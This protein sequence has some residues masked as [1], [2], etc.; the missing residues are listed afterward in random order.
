MT[1]PQ[2]SSESHIR[3]LIAQHGKI[4]FAQ[5][6][7]IALYEPGVGYYSEPARVSESGDFFTSPATHPAF[8]ALL[9]VQL[10]QMWLALGSPD[11]FRVMEMG[12]G[13]GLLGDDIVSFTSSL[14]AAFASA[15][16]Y[17]RLDRASPEFST[18]ISAPG[19]DCSEPFHCV[20][21]NELLDAFPVLL[22]QIE[23][24][25]VREKFVTQNGDHLEF[26]LD[27]VS[28]PEIAS[29]IEPYLG[30][31]P[32]GYE[33]EICLG[34]MSWAEQLSTNVTSGYVISIDYGYTRDA[35]YAPQRSLGTLQC[36]YRHTV[37]AD[38]MARIGKQDISA[39]VDFTA[40]D[41]AMAAKG[42]EA[43]ANVSQAELLT[44]LG[45]EA[46][47]D[48]LIAGGLPQQD[49]KSNQYALRALT[50][51]EGL[52][53]FRVAIHAKDAPVDGIPHIAAQTAR[54]FDNATLPVLDD[55]PRRVNLFAG[56]HGSREQIICTWGKLFGD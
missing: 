56:A 47:L 8:G 22:F 18:A 21:S 7:A 15:L 3:A 19:L 33:S 6:M 35:F 38:P 13:S 54:L 32:D 1:S 16:T 40:V 26:Q 55:D 23:N 9:T 20:L 43:I 29:R 48:R 51:P 10:H 25:T 30:E 27:D 41:E 24:G 37:D 53:R 44:L 5:F 17:Q 34:L 50:E 52:G 36:H 31:L 39:H 49:M 14:D 12:A 46:Y 45:I 4:S 2:T 42:F 28:D 11:P